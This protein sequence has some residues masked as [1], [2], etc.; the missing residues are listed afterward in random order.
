MLC[1]GR[2]VGVARMF[3][4][5]GGVRLGTEKEGGAGRG[6]KRKRRRREEGVQR[7]Y[8]SY[9]IFFFFRRA[10]C[11]C[12][13][14][15]IFVRASFFV[16]LELRHR[17]IVSTLGRNKTRR[18]YLILGWTGGPGVERSITTKGRWFAV[19]FLSE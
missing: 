2:V 1:D 8:S 5:V 14:V 10:S 3:W 15:R 18:F 7:E 16:V 9:G 13:C 17:R 19:V 4:V 11:V 6:K 12:T